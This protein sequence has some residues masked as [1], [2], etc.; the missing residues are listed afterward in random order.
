MTAGGFCW[1]LSWL[2]LPV[3]PKMNPLMSFQTWMLII[4]SGTQQLSDS[5]MDKKKS[6]WLIPSPLKPC[7]TVMWE[8]EQNSLFVFLLLQLSNVLLHFSYLKKQCHIDGRPGVIKAFQKARKI[9][10]K[11]QLEN[12]N[13]SLFYGDFF[14]RFRIFRFFCVPKVIII[15]II[16][17]QVWNN[18]KA[19]N[20]WLNSLFEVT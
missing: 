10:S 1:G 7:D 14:S 17:S 13:F 18:I 5:E 12:L 19:S 2:S 6:K 8:E 4:F 15:I 3:Q 9:I 20:V 16:K 11:F